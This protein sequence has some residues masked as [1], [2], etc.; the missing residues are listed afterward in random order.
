LKRKQI[1]DTYMA[2]IQK[3]LGGERVNILPGASDK[4]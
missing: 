3:N 1:A 4:L 2:D